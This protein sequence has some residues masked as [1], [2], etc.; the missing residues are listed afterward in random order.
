[1]AL[2]LF[3][4]QDALDSWLSAERVVL[5]GENLR[6]AGT[7]IALRLTPG[8]HF[9]GVQAGHDE[10]ALLGRAK[11]KAAVTALGA[12]IYMDSVILGETAYEIETGFLAKPVGGAESD[13]AIVRAIAGF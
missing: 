5:D 4:S 13:A 12:E 6:L 2:K 9:M 10:H 7:N 3:I 1:M 8:C 11:S